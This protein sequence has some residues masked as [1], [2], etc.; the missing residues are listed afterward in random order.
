VLARIAIST[1]TWSAESRSWLTMR[2][3]EAQ[4]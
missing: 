3:Q 2:R 1:L 4:P